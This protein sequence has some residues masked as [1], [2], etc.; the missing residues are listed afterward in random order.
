MRPL[1]VLLAVLLAGCAAA[2]PRI[3]IGP[4]QA[5][6]AISATVYRRLGS[7][8]AGACELGPHLA[9]L[10]GCTR[11]TPVA[12]SATSDASAVIDEDVCTVWNSG[13]FPP[14]ELVLELPEHSDVSGLVLVTEQTPDGVTTQIV[15]TSDDA[16]AWTE[17][18]TLHGHTTTESVYAARTQRGRRARYVRVRSVASPSWIAFREVAV[19]SC[20][21]RR[22]IP[23]ERVP[24]VD[25]S[26]SVYRRGRGACESA[27]DCS[28]DACCGPSTCVARDEAPRCAGVGC[29]QMVT[30]TVAC[31]CRAGTCGAWVTPVGARVV[32]PE[33]L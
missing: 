29:G 2:P 25:R 6:R 15:E 9:G 17:L 18:A 10:A 30:D 21:D 20:E 33:A 5:R 14:H 31:A 27:R 23:G 16:Q 19:V 32:R 8:A 3:A 11:I 13:G 26:G 28:I 22:P 4:K 24:R 7:L 12:A 1:A